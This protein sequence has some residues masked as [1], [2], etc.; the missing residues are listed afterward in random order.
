IVQLE[1]EL[2][3]IGIVLGAGWAGVRAMTC[4]SGPGISL[5][6]EFSGLGYY[7]EIPAVI[8]NVQRVGP[9][10]GLPTRTSQGDILETAFL[11]HGD[12]KHVMLFP[13]SPA[14]CYAMTFD[15]FDLAER[16]QTPVFV[17]TDLDIGMNSWL[18]DEFEYN[19]RPPDRG[20]VLDEKDLEELAARG[21][22]FERYR[23]VDGDGIPY[24]TLPGN[25]HPSGNYFTRGSG[26]NERAQYSEKPEDYRNLMNRLAKKFETARHL[27]PGPE[28]HLSEGAETGIIAYG[29]TDAAIR[30]S[31]DLLAE[32]GLKTSYLR[33][34][35]FPFSKEVRD[36]IENHKRIYV[37]E[38][39]RDGQMREL[40]IL[41]LGAD[42][43]KIRSVLHYNGIPIDA[44]T[45]AEGILNQ[46]SGVEIETNGMEYAE[47]M[48]GGE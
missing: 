48:V 21:G 31:R 17:M 15:A 32:G 18:C 7:A 35:S 36:F 3:S 13:C 8:F 41:D 47:C 16:L 20:K 26:H 39:N 40:V 24:R 4:T 9:S 45:I 38:Q 27:V 10:T 29:S 6:A 43:V 11:S 22:R 12:T 30:E 14:E 19:G 34:R 28:I 23:D 42:S 1:D 2:S 44:K 37:V 5:M 25:R 33:I 46:E